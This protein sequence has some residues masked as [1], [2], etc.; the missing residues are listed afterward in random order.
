MEKVK[1]NRHF[2]DTSLFSSQMPL[3]VY[4]FDTRHFAR[5]SRTGK[6]LA[7]EPEVRTKEKLPKPLDWPVFWFAKLE[8]AVEDGDHEASAEAQ[9]QLRRLGVSVRYGKPSIP[10]QPDLPQGDEK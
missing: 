5:H 7:K 1:Q 10:Q 3:R 8:K 6:H 4:D 9:R 2:F